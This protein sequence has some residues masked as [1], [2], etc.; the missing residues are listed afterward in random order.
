MSEAVTNSVLHGGAGTTATVDLRLTLSSRRLRVEV[1]DPLGG[2]D[3]P[4]YPDDALWESGRGLPLI[5]SLAWAWGVDPPPGGHFW[6]ELD[7]DAAP[8]C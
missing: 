8:A 2:F 7:R 5:H 4:P 1:A 3:P 6:F